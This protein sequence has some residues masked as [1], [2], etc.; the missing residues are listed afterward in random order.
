MILIKESV[1]KTVNYDEIDHMIVHDIGLSEDE[2]EMLLEDEE[3]CEEFFEEMM[4]LF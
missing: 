3:L 4:E 2:Y 1:N